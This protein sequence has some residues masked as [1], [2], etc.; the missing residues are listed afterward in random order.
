[1]HEEICSKNSVMCDLCNCS[2]M[3]KD[4]LNH[5]KNDCQ[6]RLKTCQ[7]CSNQY[8]HSDSNH[9]NVC[10][11][12]RLMCEFCGEFYSRDW[13][14]YHQLECKTM[15]ATKC[16]MCKFLIKTEL[17]DK[18]KKICG[19]ITLGNE[20]ARKK[21]IKFAKQ[22]QKPIKKFFVKKTKNYRMRK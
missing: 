10:P 9:D 3:K 6:Y 13:M 7:L 21:D 22:Y 1:M 4:F 5:V 11:K 18:H 14:R 16:N 2:V 20:I 17:F 12:K 8:L 19:A 15:N